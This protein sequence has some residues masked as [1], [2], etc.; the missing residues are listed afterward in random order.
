[1]FVIRPSSFPLNPTAFVPQR[2]EWIS[3][4]GFYHGGSALLV[5]FVL[6]VMAQSKYALGTMLYGVLS[7]WFRG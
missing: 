5:I 4:A 6:N 1:M 2:F 7:V 3:M